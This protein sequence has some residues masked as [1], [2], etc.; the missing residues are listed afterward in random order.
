IHT[1]I[2]YLGSIDRQEAGDVNFRHPLFRELST[3]FDAI[4]AY[5]RVSRDLLKTNTILHTLSEED[6]LTRLANRRS[7]ERKLVEAFNTSVER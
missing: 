6:G 2:N 1:A 5:G 7:F 3:I 4:Q